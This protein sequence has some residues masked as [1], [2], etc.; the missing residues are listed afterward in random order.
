M[1]TIGFGIHYIVGVHL[2]ITTG[3]HLPFLASILPI[4]FKMYDKNIVL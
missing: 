4:E 3:D 1:K 2:Y